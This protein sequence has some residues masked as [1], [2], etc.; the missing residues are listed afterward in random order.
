MKNKI[1]DLRNHL[2]ET[3]EALKDKES[4]MPLDRAETIGHV[5]QAIINTA[6]VEV[7]FMKVTGGGVG[8][9]FIPADPLKLVE[10][11]QKRLGKG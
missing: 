6:K 9:G 7:E 1:E 3:L 5:A 10:R 8:T 4:P 11:E 2:F